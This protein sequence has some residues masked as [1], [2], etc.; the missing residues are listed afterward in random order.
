M[1]GVCC[2]FSLSKE[3][4]DMSNGLNST[5]PGNAQQR[6]FWQLGTDFCAGEV[7][8]DAS[9]SKD[10]LFVLLLLRSFK[11]QSMMVSFQ[12][13]FGICNS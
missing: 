13:M 4:R 6:S 12:T 10:G 5:A 11:R 2:S 7:L 1:S 8:Q 9:G 3:F